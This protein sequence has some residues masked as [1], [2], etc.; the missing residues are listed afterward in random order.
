MAEYRTLAEQPGKPAR[1][2]GDVAAALKGAAKVVTA[3]YEFPY[4]RMR[5]WSRWMRS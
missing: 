3:T 4:L 1:K 2:E 5:R